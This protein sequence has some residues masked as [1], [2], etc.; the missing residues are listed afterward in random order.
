M[1]LFGFN[2]EKK[3]RKANDYL[4]KGIYYDAKV[5]FEEI[6]ARSDLEETIVGQARDGWREARRALMEEQ[7]AEAKRHAEVGEKEQAVECCKAAVEQA[8]NDLDAGEAKEILERLEQG[9][10]G[11]AKLLRGL[12]DIKSAGDLAPDSM[13]E[14]GA[15]VAGPEALFE[16]LLQ[17]LP[18]VQAEAYRWFGPEFREG[19]LQLQEGKAK[20]TLASFARVAEEVEKN[21]FFRLEKVQA[22]M[23]DEQAEEAFRLL[24]GLELPEEV[25]RRRL[26]MKVVLLQRLQRGEE[27]VQ[28]ALSLWETSPEDPDAAVL[29]A[30]VLFDNGRPQDALDV[31][32]PFHAG[33]SSAEIA[34][35]VARCY[36]ATQ[37]IQEARDLLEGTVEAFFQNPAAMHSRFPLWAAREL[38]RFYIGVG[39]D[40]AS[41]RSLVQ[42]LISQDAGSAEQYKELLRKYVEGRETL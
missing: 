1:G 31:L 20:E 10:T 34:A 22:L 9:E 32:L 33:R 27:A 25:E 21:P 29:Y 40:P 3:L 5:A 41:V 8:G 37:R 38:L 2:A 30:E 16:V 39:E 18:D 35:L 42:H 7:T 6:I 26:E 36:V 14:D 15:V 24:E 11:A 28:T 13:D 19:F 23:Q 17:S 12:D 4:A